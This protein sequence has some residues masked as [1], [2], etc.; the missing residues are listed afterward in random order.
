[1]YQERTIGT[2]SIKLAR[3]MVKKANELGWK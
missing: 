1:M 3:L 2:I